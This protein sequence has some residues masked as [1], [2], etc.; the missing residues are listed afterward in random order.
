MSKIKR[1]VLTVLVA[2]LSL[3]SV[4]LPAK[5]G[6]T[7]GSGAGTQSSSTTLAA[8]S[9]IDLAT[10]LSELSTAVQSFLTQYS[11]T[12]ST[13]AVPDTAVFA[14][15]ALT[16]SDFPEAQSFDIEL[17]QEWSKYTPTWV[18]ASHIQTI[19]AVTNLHVLPLSM[20]SSKRC[21][22][23][24]QGSD[25]F[26]LYDV[27]CSNN[28]VY[29]REVINHEYAH[30]LLGQETGTAPP[31]FD[32]STWDSYNPGG[33]S[34]GSGGA[35]T[36]GTDFV[37]SQHPE[38]GFV[39]AYAQTAIEEDQAETY[40][41]MFA[42]ADYQNL[43]G[44]IPADTALNNKV[45][46]WESYMA[47]I[48]PTMDNSY[49]TAIQNYAEA[50]DSTQEADV[51]N[52]APPFTGPGTEYTNPDGDGS[53]IWDIPL[54]TTGSDGIGIG[55]FGK[56]SVGPTQT[57]TLDGAI[58]GGANSGVEVGTNGTLKGDGTSQLYIDVDPGGT[59]APGDAAAPGCLATNNVLISGTYQVAIG[60]TQPCSG[61]DQVQVAGGTGNPVSGGATPVDLT[62]GTLDV[63]LINGFVPAVGD[64]FTIIKNQP[65]TS[66]TSTFTGLPEGA[67]FTSQGVTY[68]ITYK[69]A[70]P[71]DVVL[72]V[73]NVNAAAVAAA[74]GAKIPGTPD[75]GFALVAAHPLS[76]LAVTMVTGLMLF[77]I[78]RRLKPAIKL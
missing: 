33:F 51:S 18:A 55:L 75:T 7:G 5:V 77:V 13:A 31:N 45:N 15:S 52:I 40:A 76:E 27:D 1:L 61:Y 28:D 56:I 38:N 57:L 69:A 64:N 67:T 47:T 43:S 59:L 9:A 48:D 50:N 66:V 71:D 29:M 54:G 60:G 37:N 16:D 73:T 17:V 12:Y 32:A 39:T 68:S 34:Y 3:S 58:T 23:Y 10:T 35:S 26:M 36:Y 22:S 8:I 14:T 49:F 42:T 78:A 53:L 41:Y 62:D 11:L 25:K 44:W 19:Y 24:G 65:G 74:T 4:L 2:L 46:L 63:S 70:D 20:A 72:T 6:A 30:F 21:A